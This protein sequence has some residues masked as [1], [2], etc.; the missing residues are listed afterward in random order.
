MDDFTG[1]VCLPR[2][3]VLDPHGRSHQVRELKSGGVGGFGD[4]DQLEGQGLAQG[5]GAGTDPA[6][7]QLE[8]LIFAAAFEDDRKRCSLSAPF[9]R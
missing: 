5:I 7:G 8:F 2:A 1:R 3:E 4:H 9:T 6:K